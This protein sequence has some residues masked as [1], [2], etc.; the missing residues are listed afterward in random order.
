MPPP[1]LSK[2]VILSKWNLGR[3][4]HL[5]KVIYIGGFHQGNRD[6]YALSDGNK[7][8]RDA[9]PISVAPQHDEIDEHL[10]VFR[11]LFL[12]ALN[13]NQIFLLDHINGERKSLNSL[14]N[15]LCDKH[16]KPM[17]TL[18][19]NARILKNLELIDYGSKNNPR[20][21]ELTNGGE[22][23][24]TIIRCKDDEVS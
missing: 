18:K 19:L 16:D 24:R 1:L 7:K 21:V 4:V 15:Y 20:P 12:K 17:S 11:N 2:E 8:G 9:L 22:F 10:E 5:P 6:S 14:L 13:D 3:H 23:I